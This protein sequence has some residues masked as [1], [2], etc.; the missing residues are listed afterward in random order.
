[1]VKEK[2]FTAMI[3]KDEDGYYIASI[4]ELPGCH[5]Q[6]KSLDELSSRIKEAKRFI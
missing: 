1:M 4:L 5:T 3:E 2:V 6:A